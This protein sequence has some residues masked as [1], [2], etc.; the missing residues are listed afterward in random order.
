MA[1]DKCMLAALKRLREKQ[2]FYLRDCL[3][4]TNVSES[5]HLMFVE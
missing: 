2:Q 5:V 4:G 1:S 3:E